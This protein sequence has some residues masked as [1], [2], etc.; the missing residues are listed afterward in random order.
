MTRKLITDHVRSCIKISYLI[1][2]VFLV[3]SHLILTQNL[4][5]TQLIAGK[6]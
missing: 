5:L 2:Y 1:N 4:L 6:V 3:R